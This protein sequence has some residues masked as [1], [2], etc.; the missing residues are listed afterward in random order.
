MTNRW[1]FEWRASS[2]WVGW[3]GNLRFLNTTTDLSFLM[4]V[5][6]VTPELQQLDGS[7]AFEVSLAA[8]Y[9]NDAFFAGDTELVLTAS[10][11]AYVL[12]FE[13]RTERPRS[14]FQR[15]PWAMAVDDGPR[16]GDSLGKRAKQRGAV[17]PSRE[18]NPC[19]G[20]ARSAGS[21]G[22]IEST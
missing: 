2:P 9:Q 6:S 7:L 13:P 18:T 16:L 20:S 15:T 14:G 17:A 5:D 21:R 11:T 22:L 8:W 12:C 3:A 10:L 4:A 1:K 19:D